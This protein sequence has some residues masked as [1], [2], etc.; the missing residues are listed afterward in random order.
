MKWLGFDIDLGVSQISVPQDK[1]RSLKTQL[2]VA[3]VKTQIKAKFLAS[4]TGKIISMSIAMGP[5]TRSMTRSM[6]ALLNTR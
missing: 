1:S 4:I 5:V 3:A 2:Q 6:Y